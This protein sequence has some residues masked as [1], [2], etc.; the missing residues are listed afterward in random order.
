MFHKQKKL[1]HNMLSQQVCRGPWAVGCRPWAVG[2]GRWAV[3]RGPWDVGCGLW[4]VGRGPWAV[5]CG[6][7]A[8]WVRA[9]ESQL[10][11]GD[12]L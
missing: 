1:K 12:R 7:W 8:V 5:G 2:R 11:R 10:L 9:R 6:L 4:A 3:G